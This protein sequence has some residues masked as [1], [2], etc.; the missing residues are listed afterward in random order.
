MA[1]GCIMGDCASCGDIVWEDEWTLAGDDLIHERCKP[2][3]YIKRYHLSEDQFKRLYGSSELRRDIADLKKDLAGMVDIY[4]Q[5]ITALEK[6][7]DE[8]EKA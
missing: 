8:L 1:S 7:L 5:H 3:W 4:Q 6:A 2:E